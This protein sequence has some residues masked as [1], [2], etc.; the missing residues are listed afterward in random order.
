M[1]EDR[2][3]TQ[4]ERS[5]EGRGVLLSFSPPHSAAVAFPR[6]LNTAG[7]WKKERCLLSRR[8]I[9]NGKRWEEVLIQMSHVAVAP[10]DQE[11]LSIPWVQQRSSVLTGYISLF[12][13]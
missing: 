5:G 11:V 9:I 1:W 8:A 7:F 12:S 4:W 10:V 2:W 13:F 3:A 6:L